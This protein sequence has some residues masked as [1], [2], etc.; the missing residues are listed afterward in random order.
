MN[1]DGI[2]NFSLE[3]KS[4]D[5]NLNYTDK[6]IIE[7]KRSLTIVGSIFNVLLENYVSSKSQFASNCVQ[8]NKHY[9]TVSFDCSKLSKYTMHVSTYTSYSR[10]LWCKLL[11]TFDSGVRVIKLF[12]L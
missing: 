2:E 11:I 3:T 8:C 1:R 12:L 9:M 10:K 6:I 7:L 4:L 5:I